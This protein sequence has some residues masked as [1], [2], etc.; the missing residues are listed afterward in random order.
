MKSSTAGLEK[1][2][3]SAKSMSAKSA[4][5][6]TSTASSHEMAPFFSIFYRGI[7]SKINRSS[8]KIDLD[9]QNEQIGVT[10]RKFVSTSSAD[11]PPIPSALKGAKGNNVADAAIHRRATAPSS[12]RSKSTVELAKE[13]AA[14]E[15]KTW[16]ENVESRSPVSVIKSTIGINSAPTSPQRQ[17]R[18]PFNIRGSKAQSQEPTPFPV[19]QQQNGF[20][21][22]KAT[23][24]TSSQP[25]LLDNQQSS[26]L[27]PPVPIRRK[28]GQQEELPQSSQINQLQHQQQ[29]E[30][31]PFITP[32]TSN[33]TTTFTT[34]PP[35][36]PK[37]SFDRLPPPS[38]PFAEKPPLSP[39]NSSLP[40]SFVQRIKLHKGVRTGKLPVDALKQQTPGFETGRGER[41]F[42]SRRTSKK[43]MP[44]A[45]I[46][47]S[48]DAIHELRSDPD[49]I[50]EALMAIGDEQPK[51][52]RST[53][54]HAYVSQDIK[55]V[56]DRLSRNCIYKS[57][58][59]EKMVNDSL[60]VC[61][62]LQDHLDNVISGVRAKSPTALSSPFTTPPG[63]PFMTRSTSL[64][65]PG[66]TA[67][68]NRVTISVRY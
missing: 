63:S 20:H 11:K 45:G 35:P 57:D 30:A 55:R 26:E 21:S 54:K 24:T 59:Y 53:P 13:K 1:R 4:P 27:P 31:T 64:H 50:V 7:S 62:M 10:S 52:A 3:Q 66:S 9:G 37:I 48:A 18:W 44:G 6:K 17:R 40:M 38:L 39:S 36:L 33:T 5:P 23:T 32:K 34:R 49:Y 19:S 42:A 15:G 43:A 2:K 41:F 28:Q 8:S 14:A 68:I 12:G 67:P 46:Y 60:L 58:V 47:M 22:N 51:V 56:N 29:Q 25:T 65:F 61:D 16:R